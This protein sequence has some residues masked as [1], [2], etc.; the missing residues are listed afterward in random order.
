MKNSRL[1]Q[2]SSKATNSLKQRDPQKYAR[3]MA[4]A[5]APYKGLRAFI[6]L[7]FGSS[8]LIGALVFLAQLAAGKDVTSALPNFALQVGLVALMV[9]LFR[10]EKDN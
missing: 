1:D 3:L 10:W 9:W 6:Y 4:E 5:Q 8:G 7:A 2:R